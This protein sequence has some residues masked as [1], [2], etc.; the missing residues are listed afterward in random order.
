MLADA[1]DLHRDVVGPAA[2]IRQL[3]QKLAGLLGRQQTG[4]RADFGVAD[5]A[6]EAVAAEHED[7]ARLQRMRPLDVHLHQR[8][9]AERRTITLLLMP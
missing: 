4:H 1:N 9:G 6:A 8:V 2:E 7:I 3:H 5:R